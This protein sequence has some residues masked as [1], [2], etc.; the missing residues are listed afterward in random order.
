MKDNNIHN[1]LDDIIK[2]NS[3]ALPTKET[4]IKKKSEVQFAIE[5][6]KAD[7]EKEAKREEQI[8]NEQ[9]EYTNRL[10]RT[11][12]LLI[13]E[14]YLKKINQQIENEKKVIIQKPQKI[15]FEDAILTSIKLNDNKQKKSLIKTIKKESLIYIITS[16]FVASLVFFYLQSS[17]GKPK[18]PPIKIITV[19]KPDMPVKQEEVRLYFIDEIND[20]IYKPIEKSNEQVSIEK[21]KTKT[22]KTKKKEKPK[23]K[24][25]FDINKNDL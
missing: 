14:D 22:F 15:Q 18:N 2:S 7:I 10:K 4:S 6:I 8:Y 1:L 24:I 11:Q 13:E 19:K 16:L 5:E 12:M 21:P 9:I 17:D 3:K 23:P 20:L 25:N